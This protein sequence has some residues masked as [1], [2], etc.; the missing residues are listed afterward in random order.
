MLR[1]KEQPIEW[2]KFT[3]VIGLAVNIV[4]WLLWWR[5]ILPVALP[6]TAAT[7]AVL[8]VLTAMIRPHWFRGFYRG[9]MMVSFQIGQVIGKVLLTLFFFL[10]VTPMG[11]LLRFFGK[12]LLNLKAPPGE[13]T[14]WHE[15]KSTRE[16][17]RMF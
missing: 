9:G 10:L 14:C 12:D 7:L 8:A 15:A 3:A 4:L 17:D 11:L 16:V 2:I 5:G 13:T 6:A 1:L